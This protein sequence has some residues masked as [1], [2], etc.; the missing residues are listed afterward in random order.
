M[1]EPV[2]KYSLISAIVIDVREKETLIM[3]PKKASIIIPSTDHSYDVLLFNE[4]KN[5][6]VFLNEFLNQVKGEV[7][8]LNGF[9]AEEVQIIGSTGVTLPPLE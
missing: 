5:A 3:E 8:S 4:G 9:T 1:I 7:A 2:I 6:A